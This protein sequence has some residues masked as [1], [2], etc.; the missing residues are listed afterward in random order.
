[1]RIGRTVRTS[2]G[3]FEA[4]VSAFYRK[5]FIDLDACVRVLAERVPAMSILEVGCGDGQLAGPLLDRFPDATYH[6]I[7]IAPEVGRL[8]EGDRAR[9]HFGSVDSRT[10]LAGTDQRF[11]LVLLVDVLHHVPRLARADVLA[12]VRALTRS[13]GCYVVKDWLRSHSLVHA[14]VWVSDRILTGDRV[15]YFAP[16]ELQSLVPELFPEDSELF[17]TAVPPHHNNVL[18]AYRRS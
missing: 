11:D 4:P 2:L 18:L 1:M 7:D 3:R 12:D 5:L 13:G 6:G 16:D 17:T 14:G 9:A 15:A 10:F 8:F